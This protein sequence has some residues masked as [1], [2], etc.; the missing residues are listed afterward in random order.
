[1][2][3]FAVVGILLAAALCSAYG[4]IPCVE[5][6]D[7]FEKAVLNNSDNV[8]A[9]VRAFYQPNLPIPLSVQVVYHVKSMPP[10]R[11]GDAL[12]NVIEWSQKDIIST[13]RSCPAGNEIWMWVSSPVFIFVEPTKLNLCAL[14]T[15][16]FFQ[17]WTVRDAHIYLPI[18]CSPANRFNFL[19][20][21]TSRVCRCPYI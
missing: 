12:L 15:L 21:L 10:V 7:E 14:Y 13:D 2:S 11:T 1:M 17:T 6:F 3:T 18:I 9:L 19:N 20:G 5:T 16:N 8:Q 4:R